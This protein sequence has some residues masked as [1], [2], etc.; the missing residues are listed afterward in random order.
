MVIKLC[1]YGCLALFME[2]QHWMV[3]TSVQLKKSGMDQMEVNHIGQP[4]ELK[5]DIKKMLSG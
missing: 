2:L 3:D 5:L 1:L 4:I